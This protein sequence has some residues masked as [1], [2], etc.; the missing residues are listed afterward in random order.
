MKIGTKISAGKFKHD[1]DQMIPRATCAKNA[2]FRYDFLWGLLREIFR[3]YGCAKSPYQNLRFLGTSFENT[4]A[5]IIC[6]MKSPDQD[7]LRV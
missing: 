2:K 1:N 7:L 3:D 4:C 5:V 6:K